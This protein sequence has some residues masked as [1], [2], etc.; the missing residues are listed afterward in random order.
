[1]RVKSKVD[2]WF[3]ILI[4]ATV[5]ILV[6]SMIFVPQ[7]GKLIAY[8]VVIPTSLFMF[9]IYF[10]TYYEFRDDYLF[11]KSGPFFEKIAYDK[12]KSARLSSNML[13]SMALSIDRIEIKQHGKSYITGTTFI[14][15]ENR[16]EFMKELISR[17]KNIDPSDVAE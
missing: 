9:W 15:P 12:I 6:G 16:E 7:D 8:A 13:S 2:L 3:S 1:M 11:C 10:G 5:I 17:C 4:W 14:S